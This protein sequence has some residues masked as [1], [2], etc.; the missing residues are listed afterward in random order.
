MFE[1]EGLFPFEIVPA[2]A[3][4]EV[5]L[6][7]FDCVDSFNTRVQVDEDKYMTVSY[8]KMGHAL[9]KTCN[10]EYLTILFDFMTYSTKVKNQ[11]DQIASTT[12][13]NLIDMLKQRFTDFYHEDIYIS[14]KWFDPQYWEDDINY[15]IQ[16]INVLLSHFKDPLSITGLQK[17]KLIREWREFIALTRIQ[18]TSYFD[19]VRLI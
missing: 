11:L 16:D 9:K 12:N 8:L 7:A 14:M 19:Q 2:I 15:G 5:Y 4:T 18:Y 10:Q 3:K 17:D 13:Q 1:G 6:T